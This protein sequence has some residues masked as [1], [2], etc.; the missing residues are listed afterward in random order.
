MAG[1][2]VVIPVEKVAAG[3]TMKVHAEFVASRL[4]RLRVNI[5]VLL[6]KVVAQ[7]VG[8][9]INVKLEKKRD[10]G[11]GTLIYGTQA[12]RDLIKALG[13]P[14][15]TTGFVFKMDC[16]GPAT[17]ECTY[18]PSE[19]VVGKDDDGLLTFFKAYELREI[20]E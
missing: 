3:L 11:S 5:G 9:K 20:V 14:E 2:N 13:L 19:A 4:W 18:R 1:C 6:L 17:V 7:L 8:T 16:K 15:R 10:N 12:A